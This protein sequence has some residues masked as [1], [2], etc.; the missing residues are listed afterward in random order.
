MEDSAKTPEKSS[1]LVFI[2]SL[3]DDYGMSPSQFRIF[4]AFSRRGKC[5][6]PV[7]EI[8]KRIG[9]HPDTAWSAIRYLLQQKLVSRE[10]RHGQT[11][12]YKINPASQWLPPTGIKGAPENE[13][14]ALKP[15]KRH[16]KKRGTHLPGLKGCKGDP[17]QGSPIKV[18]QQAAAESFPPSL[19]SALFQ[20]TW[21]EWKA[22][23]MGLRNKLK[24]P[25]AQFAKQLSWIAQY[26]EAVAIEILNASIRNGWQGLFEPKGTNQR[27]KI[28]ANHDTNGW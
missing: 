6:E 24:F 9:L 7:P 19:S 4:C 13:G 26:P 8:A 1:G 20:Q 18:I 22:Y 2:H 16:P 23:R 21:G 10:S 28:K 5:F 3:V 15:S 17:D 14:H 27:P 12:V 11:S 25:D